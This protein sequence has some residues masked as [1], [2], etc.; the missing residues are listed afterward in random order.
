MLPR[1]HTPKRN[2]QPMS[3][4]SW[5][6][7]NSALSSL[8]EKILMHEFYTGFQS[9]PSRIKIWSSTLVVYLVSWFICAATTK[10]YRLGNLQRTDIY[11]SQ[12]WRLR[13]PRSRH[14]QARS[15]LR[16]AFSAS[17]MVPVLHPLEGRK[18]VSSCGR[19]DGRVREVKLSPSA[20]S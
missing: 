19:R 9:F 13:S 4:G 14:Q 5:Y 12:V 17:K 11:F 10:Y 18:S 3:V 2:P 20:L 15:L 6:R 7:D 16:S 1:Q 8:S